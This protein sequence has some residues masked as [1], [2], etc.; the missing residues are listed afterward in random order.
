MHLVSAAL[1]L[2]GFPFRYAKIAVTIGGF[3]GA[4][5]EPNGLSA[6]SK[7][8]RIKVQLCII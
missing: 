7:N 4:K 8:K 2:L 1:L 3:R 5:L 6:E